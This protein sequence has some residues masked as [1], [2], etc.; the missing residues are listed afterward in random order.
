[1]YILNLENTIKM[2]VKDLRKF[3]FENFYKQIG[4]TKKNSYYLL[5]K[6]KKRI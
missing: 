4:F 6:I 5:G 2:T 1:M 3:L